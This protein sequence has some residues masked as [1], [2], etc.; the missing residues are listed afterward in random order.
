MRTICLLAFLLCSTCSPI[1]AAGR[2]WWC[3]EQAKWLDKLDDC[4]NCISA[5]LRAKLIAADPSLLRDPD[6]L[7]AF[8]RHPGATTEERLLAI[9][10]EQDI[11]DPWAWISKRMDDSRSAQRALEY[12][13]PPEYHRI[14]SGNP[15]KV[16]GFQPKATPPR[17]RH[18]RSGGLR[19][20]ECWISLWA[21]RLVSSGA[22]AHPRW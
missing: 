4:P 6:A 5:Q 12:F 14:A 10:I 16:S 21:Q 3:P 13:E 15:T 2:P 1:L 18:R 17:P 8:F 22:L 9:A 20:L 7:I 19:S 11:K